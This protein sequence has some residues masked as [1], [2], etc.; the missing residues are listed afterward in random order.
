MPQ[1]S[2]VLREHA[3]Y[4]LTA[5]M[6]IGDVARELDFSTISRHNVVLENLAVCPTGLTTADHV[7]PCK[8]RTSDSS[9]SP[10]GSSEASHQDS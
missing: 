2:Q 4:M 9:S 10:A 7:S 8:P 1:M 6:S 3:I 5:G